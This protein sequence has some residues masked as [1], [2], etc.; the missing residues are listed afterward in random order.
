MQPK[1]MATTNAPQRVCIGRATRNHWPEHLKHREIMHEDQGL[2]DHD[3]P[4]EVLERH[5]SR[6][7][8]PTVL[9]VRLGD[10]ETL[11]PRCWC[12]GGQRSGHRPAH[13][14][15][16]TQLIPSQC[17]ERKALWSLHEQG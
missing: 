16:S 17:D 10:K 13:N 7:P 4:R 9:L 1:P 5:G 14:K 12:C 6:S 15:G 2:R 11:P 3:L 8:A